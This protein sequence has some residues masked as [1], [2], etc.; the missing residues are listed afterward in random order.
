LVAHAC[1]QAVVSVRETVVK[2]N[3]I[4]YCIVLLY[5]LAKYYQN[6]FTKKTDIAQTRRRWDFL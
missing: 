1:L 4:H 6:W 2:E 5:N 3:I